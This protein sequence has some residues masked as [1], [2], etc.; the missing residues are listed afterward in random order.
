MVL[1]LAYRKW[2]KQYRNA[3]LYHANRGQKRTHSMITRS[4]AAKTKRRGVLK[5]KR[6]LKVSRKPKNIHSSSGVS[7]SYGR[8]FNK[9]VSK[10]LKTVANLNSRYQ[11]TGDATLRAT[12]SIGRQAAYDIGYLVYLNDLNNYFSQ[13]SVSATGDFFVS[14]CH[15]FVEMHNQANTTSK[16]WIYDLVCRQDGASSPATSWNNGLSTDQGAA[17]GSY[18]L[19]YSVPQASKEFNTMWSIVKCHLVTLD[20]GCTHIHKFNYGFNKKISQDVWQNTSTFIK[21]SYACMVVVLGTLDNDSTTKSQISFGPAAVNVYVR[22]FH[23]FQYVTAS[24]L[25]TVSGTLLPTSF[26]VGG[27]TMLE[28]ADTV[29]VEVSA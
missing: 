17:A 24:K 23:Q 1:S 14:R 21:G 29:A 15:M 13:A 27:S 28:D 25:N 19:P 2:K 7:Q 11:R 4:I 22:N 16:V 26:T 9:I 3:V 18:L 20:A 8:K 5:L 6:K 10:S 12:S